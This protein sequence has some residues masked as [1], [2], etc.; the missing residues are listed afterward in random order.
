M[1][2][3]WVIVTS[4]YFIKKMDRLCFLSTGQQ[5]VGFAYL[6]ICQMYGPNWQITV[7]WVERLFAL[8]NNI[9]P[10]IN[11]VDHAG[12]GG[13]FQNGDSQGGDVFLSDRGLQG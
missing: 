12:D 3:V 11:G 7:R 2:G 4:C 13:V 9:N 6:A 8:S 5:P 10:G 1:K